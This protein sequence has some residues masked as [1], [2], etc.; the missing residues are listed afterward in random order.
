[1][2]L[3]FALDRQYFRIFKTSLDT[4]SKHVTKIFL[5]FCIGVAVKS[6]QPQE[7]VCMLVC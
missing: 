1:M 7:D 3:A 5:N 4:S 2:L 6:F